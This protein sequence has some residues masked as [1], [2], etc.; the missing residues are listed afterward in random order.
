MGIAALFSP[1]FSLTLSFQLIRCI[2]SLV[3]CRIAFF[4]PSTYTITHRTDGTIKHYV[5]PLSI[6]HS[7]HQ[8]ILLRV[9]IH[10]EP[11]LLV[12][13][14][15]HAEQTRLQLLLPITFRSRFSAASCGVNFLLHHLL[16]P[17]PLLVPHLVRQLPLRH[18]LT[19]QIVRPRRPQRRLRA[20]HLL[21]VAV[22]QL[23]LRLRE[24]PRLD[25]DAFLL[26]ALRTVLAT[27]LLAFLRR[28]RRTNL[29]SS[30]A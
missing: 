18:L 22:V 19:H 7:S 2:I 5:K 15:L 13:Q 28:R 8:M 9:H 23:H 16:A 1:S 26:L 4:V 11:L 25:L 30:S 3:K 27:L 10:L 12:R 20:Q 14:R 29:P 6:P 21:E 24:K 17:L